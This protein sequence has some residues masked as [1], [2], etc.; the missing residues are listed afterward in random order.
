MVNL[1]PVWKDFTLTFEDIASNNHDTPILF[2][3]WDWNEDTY[4]K[5][6]GEC[7]VTLKDLKGNRV[8]QLKNM[9][10]AGK[11]AG[12]LIIY[13]EENTI[14]TMAEYFLAGFKFS[15]FVALDFSSKMNQSITLNRWKHN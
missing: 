11:R 6:I 4:H 14:P 8:F 3:C 13:M 12:E 9:E 15:T 10:N 5:T 7:E 2:Q 1:D